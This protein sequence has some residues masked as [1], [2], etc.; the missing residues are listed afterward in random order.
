VDKHP[1]SRRT[2]TIN[3]WNEWV[4]GSYLEPDTETGTK[5]LDA[6]REV[7]GPAQPDRRNASSPENR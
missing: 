5:Y 1:A 7:F 6:I 3:S 4:E 2:I